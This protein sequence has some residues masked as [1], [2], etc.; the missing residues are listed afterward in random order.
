MHFL[1]KYLD[2]AMK[3]SKVKVFKPSKVYKCKKMFLLCKEDLENWDIATF[4]KQ[5]YKYIISSSE[6]INF[7]KIWTLISNNLR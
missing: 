3:K 5:N 7:L 6:T 1:S 2:K 4:I